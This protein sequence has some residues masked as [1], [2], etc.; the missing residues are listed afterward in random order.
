MRAARRQQIGSEAAESEDADSGARY[1]MFVAPL[2]GMSSLVAA[3]AGRLPDGVVRLNQPAER[4]E[5]TPQGEWRIDCGAGGALVCDGLIV[6]APAPA[7]ARLL[8]PIDATLAAEL[9]RIEHAD[10]AVVSLGYQREQ[11]GRPL[12][13]FGFV[14]PAIEKRR[15][16]AAS[17]AS[18]KFP[19]RA[20]HG[21]ELIR[22]FVGGALQGHLAMINDEQLR[23]LA[24]EELGELLAIR[25]QPH[26]VQIERWPAAMPQYHVGHLQLVE[27]I[28]QRVA[29]LSGLAL[30]GNAYAGVGIPQC[31]RSGELAAER[32][33]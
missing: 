28:E 29:A 6:T 15:I 7:A 22:V 33:V 30:A 2:R 23:A 17:F 11:I 10:S 5:R 1:S 16:L 21:F 26:L 31:I 19:G 18:V 13:G 14:V 27:R 12:D 4:V 24:C 9:N 20:P 3:L 25:G 8:Q 32:V